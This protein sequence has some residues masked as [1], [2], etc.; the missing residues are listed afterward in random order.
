MILRLRSFGR[1]LL[2]A[3]EEAA[4]RSASSATRVAAGGENRA[5]GAFAERSAAAP[6]RGGGRGEGNPR[7]PSAGA[8]AEGEGAAF[9]YE[10]HPEA[11]SPDVTLGQRSGVLPE[12]SASPATPPLAE[13]RRPRFEDL[14]EGIAEASEGTATGARSPSGPEELNVAEPTLSAEVQAPEG[15]RGFSPREPWEPPS[16]AP[17][18]PP[19][20]APLQARRSWLRQRLEMHVDQAVERY[21]TQ[22]LTSGQETALRDNPQLQA[23]FRGSRID[24]FAKDT[25]IQDAELAEVITA[26]DFFNEPDILDSVLPDWFDMTTRAQWIA[27]LHT[28]AE[29]YGS[30]AHLLD[31]QR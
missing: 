27:H 19:A 16:G 5:V 18:R 1:A 21:R 25:I 26:P 15:P 12:A 22:G 6:P 4:V 24:Q 11:R 8:T 20:T 7:R 2:E 29:R 10:Y 28:Y 31:T 9:T 17:P 13:P 14:E 30:R 23:A 3:G